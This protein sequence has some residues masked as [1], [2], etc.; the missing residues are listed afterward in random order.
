MKR[1]IGVLALSV[2]PVF[3]TAAALGHRAAVLV[4]EHAERAALLPAQARVV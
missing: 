2:T 1:K 3:G 4:E